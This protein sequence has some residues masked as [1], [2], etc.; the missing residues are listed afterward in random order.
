MNETVDIF[1]LLAKSAQ[2]GHGRKLEA[3]QVNEIVETLMGLDQRGR[4]MA[5]KVEALTRVIYCMLVARDNVL[6]EDDT[7]VV[8]PFTMSEE[9]YAAQDY[10]RGFTLDWNEDSG[11]ITVAI[12][13]A[14]EA[15]GEAVGVQMLLDDQLAAELGEVDVPSMLV[16][17]QDEIAASEQGG[18][19][20]VESVD[21]EDEG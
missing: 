1:S 5:D 18:V 2:Q 19:D 14:T 8:P 4:A 20:S 21:I 10:E 17:A 15:D 6:L 12:G 11:V 13:E 3:G 16:T 7:L 9:Y